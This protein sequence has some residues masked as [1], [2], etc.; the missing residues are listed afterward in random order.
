MVW[1]GFPLAARSWRGGKAIYVGLTLLVGFLFFVAVRV[2]QAMGR[3][4]E[5]DPIVAAWGPNLLF[6]LV[7]ALL[8]HWTR[9]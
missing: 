8:F 9:K 5:L 2:A 1:I 3:S 6:F 4:G 7:G